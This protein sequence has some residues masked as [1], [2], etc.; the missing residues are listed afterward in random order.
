MKYSSP[1]L[2]LTWSVSL[3]GICDFNIDMGD[4]SSVFAPA[5]AQILAMRIS[6]EIRIAFFADIFGSSYNK[7][8]S[9]LIGAFFTVSFHKTDNEYSIVYNIRVHKRTK[10]YPL[11]CKIPQKLI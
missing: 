9:V 1:T 7:C 10:C 4:L 6:V 3:S 2:V 11:F 5:V 8:V